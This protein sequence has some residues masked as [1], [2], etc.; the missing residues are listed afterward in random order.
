MLSNVN[1][2]P[3]VGYYFYKWEA[4]SGYNKH[5][6]SVPF[7]NLHTFKLPTWE[8]KF[9]GDMRDI[10]Q[11]WN[12]ELHFCTNVQMKNTMYVEVCCKE[13]KKLHSTQG[14]GWFF[15][16]LLIYT[17]KWSGKFLTI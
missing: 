11:L 17:V 15:S 13:E 2:T 9:F 16:L 14:S 4:T 1:Q 8:T 3:I 5:I 6:C 10:G 7:S 12:Q